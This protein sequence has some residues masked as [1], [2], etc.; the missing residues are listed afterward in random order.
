MLLVGLTGGIGSG[1]STVAE[2]LAERGA[3]VIDA[4]D[5]ARRAVAPGT[6]GFDRVVETFGRDILGRDG[7]IDRSRLAETVFGDPT[8]LR[9]LESIVHPEVARLYAEA[10]GPFRET[11]RVVV[12]SVPLL[13]ERG[14]AE[15]FDVVVLIVADIDRRIERLMRDRGMTSEQVRARTATQLS[16]EERARVADVL[17]DNDGELGRLTPQVDRL[18]LDLAKRAEAAAR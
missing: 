16:D 11:D 14:L 10:L 13:A 7:D 8:R 3:V 9:A 6:E 4:D 1:K 17:L 15:G 5:L 2:L 18:W 12:Y